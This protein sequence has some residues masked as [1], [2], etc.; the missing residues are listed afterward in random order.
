MN[1]QL[2]GLEISS[3]NIKK[4]S[5]EDAVNLLRK[6]VKVLKIHHNF[7]YETCHISENISSPD[8]GEDGRVILQEDPMDNSFFKSKHNYFQVKSGNDITIKN[9]IKEAKNSQVLKKPKQNNIA[10]I[11]F[12]TGKEFSGCN[13][14]EQKI[15]NQIKHE[16]FYVYTLNQIA[17][18]VNEYPSVA[19]WVLNKNE[20]NVSNWTTHEDKMK[21]EDNRDEFIKSNSMQEKQENFYKKIFKERGVV[22][23]VGASGL[24]KTRFAL[25][26]VKIEGKDDL[27][28][29]T[30]YGS[31]ELN[32][33]DIEAIVNKRCI[34]IV[35]DCNLDQIKKF[36]NIVQKQDSKLSLIT[37]SYEKNRSFFQN[38][39]E[40]KPDDELIEKMLENISAKNS[41]VN[42][43]E[44]IN[45]AEGFPLMATLLRTLRTDE[46]F[47]NSYEDIKEKLLWAGRDITD[48]EKAQYKKVIQALSLFEK[49]RFSDDDAD[50]E[51]VKYLASMFCELNFNNFYEAVKFFKEKHIIQQVG[52]YIH[53]RPKPLAFWLMKEK[54]DISPLNFFTNLFQSNRNQRLKESFCKKLEEVKDSSDKYKELG[55]KICNFL[56]EAK[57][58]DTEWGSKCF[59]YL[60]EMNPKFT[61]EK[62]ENVFSSQS[63]EELLKFQD[64]RRQ[65]IWALEKLAMS[66]ENYPRVARLLLAFAEAENEN[67][68]NNATGVF[69]NYFQLKL[70]GTKAH[71]DIKFQILKDI[72]NS[73][74]I[75]RK[76]IAIKALK[77][78]LIVES[79]TGSKDSRESWYPEELSDE[80]SYYKRAFNLLY[81]FTKDED[82]KNEAIDLICNTFPYLSSYAI[83][84]EKLKSNLYKGFN[85]EHI[86]STIIKQNQF[87]SKIFS[88]LNFEKD[89]FTNEAL[90]EKFQKLID[91]VTEDSNSLEKKI[92]FYIRY[93]PSKYMWKATEDDTKTYSKNIKN[94]SKE[95]STLIKTENKEE[96]KKLMY[97]FFHGDQK[98]TIVFCH[99]LVKHIENLSEFFDIL[100]F[101]IV[102]WNQDKDFNPTFLC[103][104]IGGLQKKENDIYENF[105]DKLAKNK[106]YLDFL[107]PSYFNIICKNKDIKRLTDVLKQNPE[108]IFN[109]RDISTAR[110]C[111]DVSIKTMKEF[112]SILT[113][114]DEDWCWQALQ[115]Y[116]YYVHSG[117]SRQSDK[118]KELSDILFKILTHK[119]LILNRNKRKVMNDHYL[120]KGVKDILSSNY[121]SKFCKDFMKNFIKVTKE[122]K[123]STLDLRVDQSTL[124]AC[125]TRMLKADLDVCMSEV[126]PNIN[127]FSFHYMFQMRDTFGVRISSRDKKEK[128]TFSALEDDELKKMCRKYPDKFPVFLAR[129]VLPTNINDSRH[130]SNIMLWI[131]DEYGDR[132]DVVESFSSNLVNFSWT[133]KLSIYYKK[134]LELIKGLKNHK[135]QAVRDLY[136]KQKRYNEKN[137]QEEEAREAERAKFGWD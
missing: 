90:K 72:L 132:Q 114:K 69:C 10:Y 108:K 31:K 61:L 125:F 40:F 52:K 18:F 71:P 2:Q 38:I 110:R 87:K 22:N 12:L 32:A 75:D 128:G 91:I 135:H 98:N 81:D 42:L 16:N 74:N 103:G 17:N 44:L 8:G 60:S 80:W 29:L 109:L 93:C 36:I 129:N 92:D 116:E 4:L 78:A 13:L 96:I 57:V 6:L 48:I 67:W 14:N 97:N 120:K 58:L 46:L 55:E 24:G 64:G 53:V 63:K 85:L 41:Q 23:L 47:Q 134:H 73:D 3:E 5:P 130:F 79:F 25:E 54:I 99:E 94:I 137:L 68:S 106:K 1:T 11:F 95:I 84:Y 76:K 66:E 19:R 131:L 83:Q 111:A 101:H 77:N 28:S 122:Y 133:G 113:E 127:E 56:V 49:I 115:I 51:D 30:L 65:I 27:S 45:V 37:I 86:A 102:K 50:Q 34:L 15:R 119:K 33:S 124:K 117:Q 39:I 26:S 112:L 7:I 88:D 123:L 89:R 59:R 105:L 21:E 121:K 62:F 100:L 43:T 107:V 126:M 118:V 82:V 9:I 35:D 70:S 104:F 136:L 20:I